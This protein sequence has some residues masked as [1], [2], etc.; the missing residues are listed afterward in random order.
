MMNHL[1]LNV[2]EKYVGILLWDGYVEE[3]VR[4]SEFTEYDEK[5]LELFKESKDSLTSNI[6]KG[7]NVYVDSTTLSTASQIVFRQ[8]VPNAF[9]FFD[10]GILTASLVLFDHVYL[11]SGSTGNH[12]AELIN[13]ELDEK[14]V[15][16]L[17]FDGVAGEIPYTV[18][19][20]IHNILQDDD[21]LHEE[22][23][24]EWQ[25]IF[26]ASVPKSVNFSS[27]HMVSPQ[28]FSHFLSSLEGLD[29][30]VD[31]AN[32]SDFISGSTF[33]TFFNHEISRIIGLPYLPNS[34]RGV[35][36]S[37]I[38]HMI[39]EQI[40]QIDMF[41]KIVKRKLDVELEIVRSEVS[42]Q[43]GLPLLL[44]VVIQKMEGIEDYFEVVKELRGKSKRYRKKIG[45]AI[46]ATVKGDVR[47]VSNTIRIFK[48]NY[49]AVF[50]FLKK[51]GKGSARTAICIAPNIPPFLEETLDVL[52]AGK[53]LVRATNDVG[54][55][56]RFYTRLFKPHIWFIEDIRSSARR[57]LSV[58]YGFKKIWKTTLDTNNKRLLLRIVA[59]YPFDGLKSIGNN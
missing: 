12:F 44:S 6:K 5:K 41:L 46:E 2:P 40:P 59:N 28:R 55:A 48:G 24:L 29:R 51:I 33:R 50:D 16:C 57:M 25:K 42:I 8:K 7:L 45:K 20:N 23:V 27:V 15:D 26:G 43:T 58:D 18:A 35:I 31:P 14:V 47:S 1:P 30:K 39:E 3:A 4:L 34:A 38:Y 37:K 10:L 13:K 53:Y 32:L 22:L 36:E 54:L 17:E 11:P 19:A 21:K 49:G 56:R 9:T 52:K